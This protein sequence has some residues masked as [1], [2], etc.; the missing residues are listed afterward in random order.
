MIQEYEIPKYKK[1]KKSNI[2]KSNHKSRHKHQYEECLIQYPIAFAG[3]T[4]ISTKLTGYCTICGKIGSVKNGKFKAELEQLEKSRQGNNNFLITISGEEI[5]ERYHNKLP[6][7]YIEDSFADY[8]IVER[9]NNSKG[10]WYYEE[11]NFI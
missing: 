6:I 1:S 9:E 7:F 4:H 3:R 2:S 5:Y 10:E 8:V 11:T